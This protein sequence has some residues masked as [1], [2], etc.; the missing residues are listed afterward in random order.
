MVEAA[1][2][3]TGGVAYAKAQ[4]AMSEHEGDPLIAEY[5]G[6]AMVKMWQAAGLDMSAMSGKSDTPAVSL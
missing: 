2:F 1:G 6:S 3:G 4:C 5:A